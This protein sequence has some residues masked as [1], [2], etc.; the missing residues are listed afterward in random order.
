MKRWTTQSESLPINHCSW[1]IRNNWE[2]V[3]SCYW[4]SRRAWYI[5]T[6]PRHYF[7]APSS[8]IVSFGTFSSR[9]FCKEHLLLTYSLSHG[10]VSKHTRSKSDSNRAHAR[11]DT[12]KKTSNRA[13][14]S[15]LHRKS[16]T[17][18]LSKYFRETVIVNSPTELFAALFMGACPTAPTFPHGIHRQ[19]P[20]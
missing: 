1:P 7:Q 17:F 20:L 10:I 15:R 6:W 11:P 14:A 2:I 8:F 18:R 16:P 19:A 9:K 3:I 13:Q 5:A 12:Q 4:R